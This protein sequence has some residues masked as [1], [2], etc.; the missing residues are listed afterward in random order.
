MAT[1]TLD[2]HTPVGVERRAPRAQVEQPA[3]PAQRHPFAFAGTAREYFGI[4][5]VNITLTFLTLGIYSAWAK[6]RT[7]RYFHGNTVLERATF[8]YHARPLQILKGRL[9]MACALA[10]YLAAASFV[11]WADLVL[12]LVILP[13]FVPWIMVRALRFSRRVASYRHIHFDFTGTKREAFII[14]LLL[15]FGSV[16]SVGFLYPY[17]AYRLRRYL[18]EQ[19]RFGNTEFR[20][21]G[22]PSGFYAPYVYVV[23]LALAVIVIALGILF[24]TDGKPLARLRVYGTDSLVFVSV[25]VMLAAFLVVHT[26]LKTRIENYAWSHTQL[27]ADRF[28]LELA[29]GRVL[30]ISITNLLATVA[31]AGLMIPWARVRLARYK[32]SRLSLLSVAG[33][34]GHLAGSGEAIAATGE[35]LGSALDLDLGM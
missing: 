17:A 6:V 3:Q 22:R 4:W 26:W 29:F 8:G 33:L 9:I 1:T 28:E 21:V 18:V 23:G 13:L 27:G 2:L 34:D 16:L 35:E 14:Y 12:Y 30:W 24:G 32:L 25:A 5:V 7:Q 19:S 10:A 11:P 20:F 15:S 31:S